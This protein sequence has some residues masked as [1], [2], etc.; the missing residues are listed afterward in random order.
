[1]NGQEALRFIDHLIEQQHQSPLKDVQKMVLLQVFQN[2]S[3]QEIA[4]EL[5]Y[6]PD[7]IKQIAAQ[8][9][10]LVS[11]LTGVNISRKNV[12]RVLDNHQLSRRIDWGGAIDVSRFYGRETNLQTLTDWILVDSCRLIGIVGLGGIGKTAL[13]VK[14]ADQVQS[15]FDFVMWRSIK[16]LPTPSNLLS[17]ILSIL[18]GVDPPKDSSSALNELLHQLREKRCLLILDNIESV[19]QI[20]KDSGKYLLGYEIYSQIF[21]RIADEQ[22]SSCLIFTGREKPQNITNREGANLPVRSL[23]LFG[24]ADSAAQNILQDKGIIATVGQQQILIKSMGGNP[25]ALQL[26]ATTIQ[27]LFA[28]DMQSFL[29]HGA[30]ISAS[31]WNLLAQ[32]FERLSPIQQEIMYLLAVNRE[33]LTPFQIHADFLP[34]LNFTDLLTSLEILRNRALIEATS[35]GLTQQPVIMEYV[36]E[37]FLNHIAKELCSGE[38]KLIKTHALMK[39]QAPDY[40]RDAQVQL[41]LQPLVDRLASRFTNV[42]QLQQHLWKILEL[43]RYQDCQETGYAAGNLINL[44]C[45]LKADFQGCDLSHLVIRQAYLA[46][47]LLHDVDFSKSTISQTVFTET[48]GNVLCTTFSSD[49]QFLATSYDN[50]AIQVW[51]VES[52]EQ[53]AYFTGHLFWTWSI[54]FSPDGNFLVS[55]GDDGFVK[56]WSMVTNQCIHIYTGHQ[57]FVNSATFSPDGQIIASCGNDA[58]IRLWSSFEQSENSEIRTLTGHSGRIWQVE[59]SPDGQMLVSGGE[60]YAIGLWDVAA[61]ECRAFWPAHESWVRCVKFSP[62]GRSIA[63]GSFD[64]TIKIWD[65]ATQ[66]CLHHLVGHQSAISAIAYSPDGQQLISSSFDRTIKLWDT[67]TGKCLR[68]L[69]GHAAR[70]WSVAFHPAGQ[71]IASGSDDHSMKLWDLQFGRCVK[72]VTGHNDAV[73]ALAISPNGRYL[74]SGYDDSNIRIWDI[75]SAQVVVIEKDHTNRVWSV[76]FSPDGK[77]LASGSSDYT[78]K[79][80]DSAT[81]KCLQTLEGCGSWVWAVSFSPDGQTLASGSCDRVVRIWDTRNG[82]CL[83]QLRGHVSQ[84]VAVAFSPDGKLIASGGLDGIIQLWH[85]ATG[86]CY[87]Q[88]QPH[89]NISVWSVAFSSDGQMLITAGYNQPIR[90]WSVVTGKCLQTLDGHQCSVIKAR[91]SPDDQWIVSAGI[92]NMVR[93]WDVQTGECIRSLSGHQGLVQAITIAT[94]QLTPTESARPAIFSGSLDGT[95][96]IWDLESAEN[97]AT[98]RSVRPCEGAKIDQVQGLS[99]AQEATL[100]KLGAVNTDEFFAPQLPLVKSYS[101]HS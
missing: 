99:L 18:T 87:H 60:D 45:Y 7:Y 2:L 75:I 17:E 39:S 14:I 66:K 79:L 97:L 3:Y 8:L 73:L 6:G 69:F 13:S 43:F 26:S 93:V 41:V 38:L 71:F 46:Q 68:T 98:W 58:T 67:N 30:T 31:L 94:V 101:V 78:I 40:L 44:L 64:H 23:Q 49:S 51:N 86:E 88:L 9:W 85:V 5:G 96:K 32:Q 15:E 4:Q 84:V 24:V 70:V 90:I 10:K 29:T 20:G 100:R 74:A 33:G 72:T 53:V 36:A 35:Q 65:T 59:F 77:L 47:T 91:F 50:G 57:G 21:D 42:Y 52:M 25:L 80:R 56:L 89:N 28:G 37:C 95:I 61:G 82:K 11:E 62:D 1:M 54:N 16:H 83:Q 76:Q 34:A 19:L 81:G 48:C 92:D 12:A 27:N 22:H 55:A 63:S